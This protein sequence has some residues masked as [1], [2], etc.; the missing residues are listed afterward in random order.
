MVRQYLRE[1][2]L[3]YMPKI[4]CYHG[5]VWKPKT[6]TEDSRGSIRP[7]AGRVNNSSL[8]IFKNGCKKSNATGNQILL[9]EKPGSFKK[10]GS[11][12]SGYPRLDSVRE[13]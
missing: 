9:E 6:R 1:N 7:D 3:E 5:T 11:I 8:S 10:P 2:I 12:Y 13:F 4:I